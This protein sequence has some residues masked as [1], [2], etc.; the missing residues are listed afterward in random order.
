MPT[1]D[2]KNKETGEV[3]ERIIKMSELDDFKTSNPHL[4]IQLSTPALCNSVRMSNG[5]TK[6]GAFKEVLQKIHSRTSGSILN[7]TTG[8]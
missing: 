2:F 5:L 8:I 4:E 6:G 1:Y 7:Q 3:T